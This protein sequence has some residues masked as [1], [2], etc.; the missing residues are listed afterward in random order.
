MECQPNKLVSRDTPPPPKEIVDATTGLY[1]KICD[2]NFVT[3]PQINFLHENDCTY[4]QHF[5]W[6]DEDLN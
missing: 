3:S 6:F 5:Y 1:L 4:G 2:S